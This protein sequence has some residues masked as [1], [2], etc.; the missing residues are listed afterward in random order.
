MAWS[1]KRD[2][3]GSTGCIR[4]EWVNTGPVLWLLSGGGGGGHGGGISGGD[5]GGGTAAAAMTE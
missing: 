1:N 4:S 3:W 2:L 5:D